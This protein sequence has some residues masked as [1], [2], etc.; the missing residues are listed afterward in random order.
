MSTQQADHGSEVSRADSSDVP[1]RSISDRLYNQDLA[2]TKRADRPWSAYNVFTLWANDVHSLGNYAFAIGL[3][4]LG[5]GGWQI[6]LTFA[7]GGLM[8][9]LLLNLSGYAGYKTGVPFPVMSRIAFG[10]RGGQISSLVRGCVAIAWFGIQT[11]LASAVLRVMLIAIFPSLQDLDANS[12]LG[13]S[14]LGWITFVFLWVVQ[15]VIASYGM[16]M[17]RRYLSFAGPV[18]LVTLLSI[19]V[20]MFIEAGGSI[21]FPADRGP[22]GAAMW[23]EI[24]T[25]SALWVVIYGTFML[26]FCDFTRSAKSKSCIT[27]GNFFGIFVN[28]LFFAG[29]VVVLAGAQFR[30]NGQIIESPQDVVEKIP[31]LLLLSIAC[32]VLVILTIAVNL[33]A[34]FV[35]PIYMFTNLLPHKVDFRGAAVLTAIFGLVILPWNLYN[36]PT[37]I[38]YFLGGLGAALGPVF[39]IIMA[40]Y[41][42][43]RRARIDIPA[44]YTGDPNGAYH[45]RSGVNRR[46]FAALIP[47]CGLAVVLALVPVF[48]A[49]SGYSWFFGAGSAAVLYLVIADRRAQFQDVD[50]ED[51]AVPSVG[52]H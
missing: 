32:L 18:V 26:N 27:R 41:W 43:L 3:F 42:V 47:A 14:T 1:A 4:A 15:T 17:I 21:A 46:A 37:M 11:Y 33:L 40:D 16:E 51:I 7:L 48:E 38:N 12:F 8:I 49:V 31:N 10:I 9:L 44:L 34:N 5:L 13:L 19:A 28:M 6:L 29:I 2:P 50:G 36:S 20:W 35:A 45:Y 24:L 25:G 39:G 52:G 30:I 22:T 23:G